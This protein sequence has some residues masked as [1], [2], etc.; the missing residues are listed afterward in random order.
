[1]PRGFAGMSKEKRT[2]IARKGGSSVPAAK[3]SF[4]KNRDL[5][6]SAG[7]KGGEASRGGGRKKHDRANPVTIG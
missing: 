4:A 1:M 3:R 6:A 2:A 5:A 7:R